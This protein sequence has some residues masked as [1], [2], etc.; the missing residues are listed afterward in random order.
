MGRSGRDGVSGR[1]SRCFPGLPPHGTGQRI[2]LFGGS[3]NPPH[4]GHRAASLLALRR[5]ALDAVWWLVT[6][7]NPLKDHRGL[8]PIAERMAAAAAVAAHP[9]IAVTAVEARLGLTYSRD[10]VAALRRRSP[11][12][13]FVFL[14]GADALGELH[15]WRR[16][17]DLAAS[18]PFAVIDRP[19]STLRAA[20]GVAAASLAAARLDEAEAPLLAATPPPAW[21]FLHGPRSA[22]SSTA[23]RAGRA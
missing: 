2:G 17:R 7:G 13:R 12:T 10:V 6:P 9:R 20:R 19:G 1:P 16:W 4:E 18:V 21:V 14:M 11:A 22:I 23:I 3:F 15:R 8:P 5:L